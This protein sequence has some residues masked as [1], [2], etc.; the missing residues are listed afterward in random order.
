M[1]GPIVCKIYVWKKRSLKINFKGGFPTLSMVF[2]VFQFA[3]LVNDSRN[4]GSLF[5][6]KSAE[7]TA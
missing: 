6:G 4:D 2:L 5:G 1:N 7:I 3:T